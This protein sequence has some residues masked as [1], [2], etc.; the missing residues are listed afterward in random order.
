[1]TTLATA[2]LNRSGITAVAAGNIGLPLIDAIRR[3][4][5]VVVA[6]VS[7]FQLQF[8]V[9]F[10]P[11]VSCW[12]N[13][14]EDHLDWH[15]SIDHYARAKAQVWAHQGPGDVAV[16][17]ADDPT[18]ALASRKMPRG[19]E[20]VW[21]STEGPADYAV[22][23]GSLIG[24][25][26]EVI[27]RTSELPRAFPHDVSNSLAA[28]AIAVAA[29]ARTGACRQALE[30]TGPLPHR[31]AF[32]GERDGVRWYEDSKA[33]TPAS[34]RAAAAGF[35]SVV[36]IAGGRNKG[37]DLSVLA[38]LAPPVHAVVAIGEAAGEVVAAFAGVVPVTEAP[39]MEAAVE[40]A[41]AAA[42]RGDAVVLS[43]GCASF[44]WYRSYG[45]RGDHFA[46]IVRTLLAR[47]ERGC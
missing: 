5:S 9:L 27:A 6:E 26:G 41:A 17:N 25:G 29:G 23:K 38:S 30:E 28:T 2:M 7:S 10:H 35:A 39:T 1:V 15:P 33:T 44:D 13:L 47:E 32:L 16:V 40:S 46:A 4:V 3:E 8:T 34:V 20:R 45:E 36:L 42:R 12:L 21:Y 14:A 19:V 43:P 11:R 18:V 22:S 37:L 24:P 31:L